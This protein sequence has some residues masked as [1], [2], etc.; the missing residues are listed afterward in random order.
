MRITGVALTIVASVLLVAGC[1]AGERL[2]DLEDDADGLTPAEIGVPSYATEG[3][4]LATIR[5][6]GSLDA[7]TFYLARGAD[8]PV[9]V[10][11]VSEETWIGGCTGLGGFIANDQITV[12]VVND[13]VPTPD[14][15]DRVGNNILVR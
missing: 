7:V 10:L 12:S 9:C 15:W 4:D 1:S 11:A 2:S 13:H 6:A 3:F 5:E 8:T 14:G